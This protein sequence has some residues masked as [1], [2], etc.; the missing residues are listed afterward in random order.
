M[1]RPVQIPTIVE[2]QSTQSSQSVTGFLAPMHALVLLSPGDDQVVTLFDVGAADIL[3]LCPPFS[4][5]GN[6]RL[7]V[8]Q[9][10]DQ[11]GNRYLTGCRHPQ[12]Y[13]RFQKAGN[14]L[15]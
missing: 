11:K 2:H 3:T 15:C 12:D 1:F 10:V 9:V 7:A 6:V 4:V 14:T 8:L 5:V 13:A